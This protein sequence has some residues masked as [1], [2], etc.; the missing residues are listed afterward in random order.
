MITA[1]T[2]LL[3]ALGVSVVVGC[4]PQNRGQYVATDADFEDY[5]TWTFVDKVSGPSDA[6][7][8]A[9]LSDDPNVTRTIYIKGNADRTD[10]G[11]FPVGTTIVKQYTNAKGVRVGAAAMVKRGGGFNGAAGDWEWFVL[12]PETGKIALNKSGAPIRGAIAACGECHAKT[13][14]NDYVF[15][16]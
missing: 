8:S 13:A 2:F 3:I 1:R 7:K 6:L 5:S 15:T 10:N 14:E 12:S 4:M 11:K 16:R 9:H